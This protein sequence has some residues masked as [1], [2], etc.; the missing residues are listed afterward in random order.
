M[1][2]F[3]PSYGDC[4]HHYFDGAAA[5]TDSCLTNV[6]GNVV[7]TNVTKVVVEFYN[8]RMIF[9]LVF[10]ILKSD[11]K[12]ECVIAIVANEIVVV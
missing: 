10:L 9:A 12:A 6:L 4:V 2:Q 8:A 11:N 1:V 7:H 5:L 3:F